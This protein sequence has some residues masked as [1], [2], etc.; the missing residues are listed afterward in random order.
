MKDVECGART[1]SL[2]TIHG[3]HNYGSVLQAYATRRAIES[4]GLQARIIDYIPEKSSRGISHIIKNV[5]ASVLKAGNSFLK[6]C[7]PGRPHARY[8]SNYESAKRAWYKMVPGKY[9]S[10]KQLRGQPPLSDIYMV[11]SDQ[12]WHP[13]TS[14]VDS[15][16]FLDFAP[17]GKKRVAFASS[18]GVGSLPRNLREHYK[19]G[20][21][22]L[23]EIYVREASGVKLVKELTGRTAGLV[24][25]P[26]LLISG[27]DWRKEAVPPDIG[28]PYILCYGNNPAGSRYME[29]LAVHLSKITG[30][31]VVRLNGKFHNAFDRKIKYVLSAGP[32]EWL[33]WMAGA[34]LVLAQSFHATAYAVNF[35][36]PFVSILHGDKG[37]DSRQVDFLE[38]M[39]LSKLSMTSGDDPDKLDLKVVS[40]DFGSHVDALKKSRAE[41]MLALERALNQ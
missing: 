34:S 26:T 6:D 31:E 7:L 5:Q 38:M 27:D 20:L 18:F 14:S 21:S 4:L 33:G 29:N 8:L 41:S 2:L 30:W 13:R 10:N 16:F 22:N 9:A 35:G 39:G 32:R 15:S 17:K 40:H 25:D 12:V 37:R 28:G 36:V 23:D 1:V 19:R 3:I 11:G 24:L